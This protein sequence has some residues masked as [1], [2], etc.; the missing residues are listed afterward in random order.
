MKS[1]IA[2]IRQ[3]K[4]NEVKNAL[5]EVGCEGMNVSEVKGRGSQRGIRE[6]YRGSSFCIDLIPKTRVEIVVKDEDVDSIVDA[7][8]NSAYTG[9]IGDGKIFIFPVE[10]VIR[11]RTGEEGD[12]AI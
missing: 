7:I 5:L 12:S 9:N 3:E 11:I 6:S 8:R 10:N 4:F 2:I 1:I